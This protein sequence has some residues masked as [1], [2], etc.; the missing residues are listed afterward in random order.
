MF[1]SKYRR[2]QSLSGAR[3]IIATL[4]P[5][6]PRIAF[7]RDTAQQMTRS[8][9][10]LLSRR[11]E[12]LSASRTRCRSQRII[13]IDW[14][15]HL[16]RDGIGDTPGNTGTAFIA[17]GYE[18]TQSID[19]LGNFVFSSLVPATYTLELQFR[20]GRSHCDRSAYSNRTGLTFFP[21]ASS[22]R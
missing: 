8:D 6:Q 19:E 14:V 22:H 18:T 5:P 17:D 16:S 13:A 20:K 10:P 3:K 21:D 2:D 15:C 12:Y 11:C 9:R 1:W 4:L 7:Q